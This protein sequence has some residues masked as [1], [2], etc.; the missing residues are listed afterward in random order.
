M[1]EGVRFRLSRWVAYLSRRRRVNITYYCILL[2]NAYVVSSI[3][4]ACDK[5]F[6]T[7]TERHINDIEAFSLPL[8]DDF[9]SEVVR[10]CGYDHMDHFGFIEGIEECWIL[11]V[12]PWR[13]ERH[14]DSSYCYGCQW[15]MQRL[16]VNIWIF[17][18]LVVC[19][20][21]RSCLS[22][23]SQTRE[24]AAIARPQVV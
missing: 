14:I 16:A 1:L 20:R 6:S 17:G 13:V 7:V 15:H 10:L 22:E 18:N 12:E 9:F 2:T 19:T 8:L 4:D 23:P 24:A 3:L 21:H 11:L 5:V